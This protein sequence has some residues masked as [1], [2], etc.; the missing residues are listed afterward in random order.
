MKFDWS[1]IFFHRFVDG[2]WNTA[3]AKVLGGWLISHAIEVKGMPAISCC[4]VPDPE[5]KWEIDKDSD[6]IES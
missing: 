5:H 3:R 4:F 2:S 6:K 1:D